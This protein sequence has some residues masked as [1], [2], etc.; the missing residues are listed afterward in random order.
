MNYSSYDEIKEVIQSLKNSVKI[1]D[2]AKVQTCETSI[3][4][5]LYTN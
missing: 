2:V 4:I 3:P 5:K 1:K